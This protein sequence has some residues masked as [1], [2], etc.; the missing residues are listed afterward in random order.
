[1]R[2]LYSKE[3]ILKGRQTFD[4]GG[5]FVVC[6]FVFHPFGDPGNAAVSVATPLFLLSEEELHLQGHA[7]VYGSG[8]CQVVMGVESISV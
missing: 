3:E 4:G 2:K 6:F 5:F 1:M 7:V 8:Q